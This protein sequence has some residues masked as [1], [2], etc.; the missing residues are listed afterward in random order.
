MDRRAEEAR[1]CALHSVPVE[2]RPSGIYCSRCEQLAKNGEIIVAAC[3]H[4]GTNLVSPTVYVRGMPMI[5]LGWTLVEE[6]SQKAK[7][8]LYVSA[9]WGDHTLQAHPVIPTGTVLDLFCPYCSRKL[10]KVSY[11]P[12]C[13]AQVVEL[14]ALHMFGETHGRVQICARRGCYEHWRWRADGRTVEAAGIQFM[15]TSRRNGW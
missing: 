7:H 2:I 6:Q 8:E 11:C 10:P 1:V 13:Q 15:A 14:V 5:K 9:V 4:C 3:P 12:T